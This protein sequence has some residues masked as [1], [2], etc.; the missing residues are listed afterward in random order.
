MVTG[1]SLFRVYDSEG[2]YVN[3]EVEEGGR[4]D[5]TPFGLLYAATPDGRLVAAFAPGEWTQVARVDADDTE[6][7]Q[8]EVPEPPDVYL[9]SAEFLTCPVGTLAADCEGDVWVVWAPS[10][11]RLVMTVSGRPFSH[12]AT[13]GPN[14]FAPFR[15]VGRAELSE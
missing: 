5:F 9:T 10:S 14:G 11:A 15:V 13:Y 4:F 3:L 1:N 8:V 2:D 7:K 12:E 6:A